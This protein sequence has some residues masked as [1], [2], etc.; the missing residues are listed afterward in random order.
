M[1]PVHRADSD[2][3]P[4]AC[5]NRT[6][7]VRRRALEMSDFQSYSASSGDQVSARR[8]AGPNSP[9][10]G[11]CKPGALEQETQKRPTLAASWRQCPA[12]PRAECGPTELGQ[13]VQRGGPLLGAGEVELGL[14][15]DQLLLACPAERRQLGVAL[16]PDVSRDCA[17][18][19][20][21]SEG[22]GR[23]LSTR[24]KRTCIRACREHG[25]GWKTP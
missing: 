3:R 25:A 14:E 16:S 21:R 13:G 12:A 22:P 1:R 17:G 19:L 4:R 10:S 15:P 8:K 24:P 9:R 7:G 18:F 5:Q 6:N 20:P 23:A 2:E 11:Q